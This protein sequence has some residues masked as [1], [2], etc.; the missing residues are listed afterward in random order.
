MIHDCM[1]HDMSYMDYLHMRRI[2]LSNLEFKKSET[3]R[4]MHSDC[5]KIETLIFDN[6]CNMTLTN[7]VV[8]VLPFINMCTLLKVLYVSGRA[9]SISG[10]YILDINPVIASN[11]T[12]FSGDGRNVA[13]ASIEHMAV[14][15]KLLSVLYLKYLYAAIPLRSLLKLIE[16]NSNLTDL[17]ITAAAVHMENLSDYFNTIAKSCTM[18]RSVQFENFREVELSLVTKLLKQC[19]RLVDVSVRGKSRDGQRIDIH[20]C[21]LRHSPFSRL[22][23]S[24]GL[25]PVSDVDVTELLQELPHCRSFNLHN[26]SKA[27]MYHIFKH[28]PR[29]KSFRASLCAPN[30]ITE[31]IIAMLTACT[32][33]EQLTLSAGGG[34]NN[35]W[36][37]DA[38]FESLLKQDAPL[39][40]RAK[41]SI[42]L[43]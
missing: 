11:L 7:Y 14:H 6:C 20:R 23:L 27:L 41:F 13:Q 10:S 19:G 8:R 15:C 5:S 35:S 32:S 24:P 9:P 42:V 2:K 36:D 30:I 3:W 25:L 26:M 22:R 12:F 37:I 40:E 34:G 17:A 18:I 38:C 33:L 16:I 29:V 31:D 21:L 43:S 39:K 4:K 28:F 1:R